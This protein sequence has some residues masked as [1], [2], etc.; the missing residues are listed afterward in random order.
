MLLKQFMLLPTTNLFLL[1]LY[2]CKLLLIIR[3]KTEVLIVFDDREVVYDFADLNEITL[4][5]IAGSE[6]AIA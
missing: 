3:A 6:K 4:A 5:L 1:W 2:Y